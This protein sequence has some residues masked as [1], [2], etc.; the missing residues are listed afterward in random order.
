MD[1]SPEKYDKTKMDSFLDANTA[2]ANAVTLSTPLLVAAKQEENQLA[3]LKL[4]LEYLKAGID[5]PPEL[6]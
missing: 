3:K 4:R 6:L 1:P 5:L 2:Q